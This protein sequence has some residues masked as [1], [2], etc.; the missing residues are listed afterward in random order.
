M[1]EKKQL[2]PK[3]FAWDGVSF[4]IPE[5]WELAIYKFPKKKVTRL[6]FED[7]YSVRMEIEWMRPRR[8]LSPTRIRERYEKQARKLTALAHHQKAVTK[9][10]S[11]WY[12]AY[13][14]FREV[15]PTKRKRGLSVVPHGMVT[16]FYLPPE[17]D[18][19]CFVI[20]HEMPNDPEDPREVLR[21]VSRNFYRHD[22]DPLYPWRL[23]DI[24]FRLPADFKLERAQFAVGSKIMNFTWQRRRFYLWFLSC[25]DVI[26]KDGVDHARWVTGFLNAYAGFRGIHFYPGEGTDVIWKRRSRYPFG[27]RDEWGRRCMQYGIHSFV[28][29]EK[30]QL[31]IWVMQH[32]H[33]RDLELIPEAL[34]RRERV[35]SA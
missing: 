29:Q 16:A 9:L 11:G 14:T 30:N 19:F 17:S 3:P 28:D 8:A 15:I 12:G 27:H 13:F 4:E 1:P 32:R 6:E 5:N 24:A 23:Y 26:L 20:I 35:R 22:R 33:A 10:P 2:T 31:V 21:M 18:F 7:E 25:A 34:K